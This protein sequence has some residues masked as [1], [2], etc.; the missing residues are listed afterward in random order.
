VC[1][2]RFDYGELDRAVCDGETRGRAKLICDQ[3]GRIL[4]AS[5]LG[6]R[7]GEAASELV[8]AVDNGLTARRLGAS[9]HVYPTFSRIARRLSDQVFM[10]DG[11]SALT[12]RLFGR[13]GG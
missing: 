1:V 5:L 12:V 11:A 3:G 13:F 8:V 10:D 6:P 9:I 2:Y 7:A 4:G